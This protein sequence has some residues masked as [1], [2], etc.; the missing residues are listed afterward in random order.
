[1]VYPHFAPR[2][3]AVKTALMGLAGVWLEL[4]F[5]LL[6]ALQSIQPLPQPTGVSLMANGY[7]LPDLISA[8]F[9]LRKT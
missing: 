8:A 3:Y 6:K 4:L 9:G 2:G 5:C 1:M 7:C